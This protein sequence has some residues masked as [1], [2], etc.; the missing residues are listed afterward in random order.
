MYKFIFIFV[1]FS[2]EHSHQYPYHVKEETIDSSTVNQQQFQTPLL[3]PPLIPSSAT[4]ELI[5]PLTNILTSSPAS[6]TSNRRSSVRQQKRRSLREPSFPKDS[7]LMTKKRA[8]FDNANVINTDIGIDNLN[9]MDQISTRSNS[10]EQ[11]STESITS[12]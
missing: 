4:I 5:Q 8:K 3:P 1:V 12:K 2:V 11:Q 10:T 9:N 6:A 7:S